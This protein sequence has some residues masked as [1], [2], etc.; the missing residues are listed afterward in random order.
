MSEVL[1]GVS[2]IPAAFRAELDIPD[3]F[4]QSHLNLSGIIDENIDPTVCFY[5]LSD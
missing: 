5:H 2:F 1:E 4:H 3:I